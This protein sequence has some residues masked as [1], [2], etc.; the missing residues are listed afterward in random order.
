MNLDPMIWPSSWS[1]DFLILQ[2]WLNYEL[3]TNKWPPSLQIYPPIS[4]KLLKFLREQ[5]KSNLFFWKLR[6]LSNCQNFENCLENGLKNRN[7][8]RRRAFHLLSPS[9]RI[10]V[11]LSFHWFLKVH[12][13]K[14]QLYIHQLPDLFD[15]STLLI[16]PYT[17]ISSNYDY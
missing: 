12:Y 16:L 8:S 13:F 14:I 15:I 17:S 4:K 9:K 3:V 7:M 11:L 6:V 2:T 10:L 1:Y 5:V